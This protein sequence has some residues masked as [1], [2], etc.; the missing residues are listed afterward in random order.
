MKFESY[1]RKRNTQVLLEAVGTNKGDLRAASKAMK[2]WILSTYN[3]LERIEKIPEISG[4]LG[5]SVQH[6]SRGEHTLE[7]EVTLEVQRVRYVLQDANLLDLMERVNQHC[8]RI[9]SASDRLG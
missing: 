7:N 8:A 1:V 6:N 9:E 3:M 2:E 4:E 5:G